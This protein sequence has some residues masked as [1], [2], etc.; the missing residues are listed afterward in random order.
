MTPVSIKDN[1]EPVTTDHTVHYDGGN[2][3]IPAGRVMGWNQITEIETKEG[4][5]FRCEFLSKICETRDEEFHGW[6]IIGE[7]NIR[8]VIL[9]LEP[10]YI[11]CSSIVN[12]TPDVINAA[13]GLVSLDKMPSPM[14]RA[15][16]PES[17]I[18]A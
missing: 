11:I 4:T 5:T 3:D 16:P 10:P 15:L 13:S 9:G 7:P 17:Y 12:R 1:L 14:Y 2:M 18:E 8:Q 6:A